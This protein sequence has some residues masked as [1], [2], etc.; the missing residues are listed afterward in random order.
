M[1]VGVVRRLQVGSP[2]LPECELKCTSGVLGKVALL[3]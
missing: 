1:V 3:G 2:I